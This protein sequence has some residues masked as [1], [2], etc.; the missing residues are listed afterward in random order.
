MNRRRR[1]KRTV[2]W[3][4][5]RRRDLGVVLLLFLGCLPGLYV[6][7]TRTPWKRR[8]KM[9]VSLLCCAALIFLALPQTNP[10]E[11]P[12]GGIVLVGSS[13]ETEVYG[14]EA[15][16][17]REVVE[18]YTPIR[19]PIVLQSTPQPDPVYVY[20]NDGGKYYHSEEC[21]YVKENTPKVTLSR[22]LDAGYS[23]CPDCSAPDG[24]GY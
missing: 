17:G 22:A 19:T 10:P 13:V 12:D 6:M 7:W 5:K 4:P 9:A 23:R 2:F 21:R 24:M 1:H 15:P 3:T 8:T 14:P 20:C 11:R 16:E 18:V